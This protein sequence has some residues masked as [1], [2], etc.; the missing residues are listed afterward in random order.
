MAQRPAGHFVGAASSLALG[1]SIGSLSTNDQGRFDG[2][3]I[4]PRDF[5]VGDYDLMVSTAGDTRC[6]PGRT[7]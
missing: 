3:V 4:V 7:P 6:G 2:A 1:A 5:A